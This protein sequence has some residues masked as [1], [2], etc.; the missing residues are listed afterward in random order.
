ML[1]Q[2]V[3]PSL[4]VDYKRSRIK[5]Y[6]KQGRALRT[7]TTINDP[8]DFQVGK[9]LVNLP[10]LREIGFRANRRLLSVQ[11][12]SHDPMVGEQVV[13]SVVRPVEVG[14]QHAAGLRFDDPRVQALLNALLL[15]VFQPQGF[16]QRDLRQ[17]LSGLLGVV[18]QTL[19]SGRM[20]YD[21]RRLRLH[22]LIERIPK[23]H[24][25][26]LT[27]HGR[28]VAML[29]SRLYAR[30]LRPGAAQLLPRTTVD[31]PQLQRAFQRLDL[32]IDRLCNLAA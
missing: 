2:G 20:T 19:T 14:G 22:G 10:A 25:Y 26:T 24:R 3:I 15:F 4:H 11:T 28:R 12:I 27:P 6:H 8:R 32:E 29:F 18:P 16:A 17:A 5:Q 7:E 1:T 23:T 9:R 31:A 13:Q 21:L 30:F